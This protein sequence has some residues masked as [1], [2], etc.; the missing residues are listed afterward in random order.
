M[1][2]SKYTLEEEE[3][4]EKFPS[5]NCDRGTSAFPLCCSGLHRQK[6]P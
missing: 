3:E 2:G 6:Y 1:R 5:T 4:E